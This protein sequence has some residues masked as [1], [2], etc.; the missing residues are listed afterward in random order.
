V[1]IPTIQIGDPVDIW[2]VTHASLRRNEVVRS[3]IRLLAAAIRRQA[4]LFAGAS[5]RK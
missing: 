5:D 1:R 4:A 2:L 3:L